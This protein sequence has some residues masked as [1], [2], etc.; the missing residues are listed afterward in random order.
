MTMLDDLSEDEIEQLY[1][2]GL[3]SDEDVEQVALERLSP[4]KLVMLDA[5]AY[6]IAKLF[7]TP[8]GE[9]AAEAAAHRAANNVT[10]AT[11]CG[12][13]PAR[14]DRPMMTPHDYIGADGQSYPEIAA[15]AVQS[16]QQQSPS[17]MYGYLRSGQQQKVYL[18]QA[19]DD[20]QGWFTALAHSQ[21]QPYDY[22]AV[23]AATNLTRPVPG[24]ESFGHTFVS[25]D[26]EIGSWLMPFLLGLPVGAA[27]GYFGPSLYEKASN[28]W[29]TRE[30]AKR[31]VVLRDQNVPRPPSTTSGQWYDIEGPS[32]G[33]PWVDLEEPGYAPAY[34]IGSWVDLVGAQPVDGA[35]RRAHAQSRA[36]IQS[37]INEVKQNAPFAPGAAAFVWSLDPPDAYASTDLSRPFELEGT[38]G[39][40]TF[41]SVADALDYMRQRIQTP[42]VALAL[43]DR[44]SAHWPNP[45]NWTKSTDPTYEPVIA[46]QIVKNAPTRT[47]GWV[48][49]VGQSTSSALEAVRARAKSLASSKPGG[50]AAGVIHSRVDGL[51]H[52]FPFASL[53]DAIDW[54][55]R[56]TYD[57][58]SFTYAAAY[59]KAIDGRAYLQDEEIG[60]VRAVS[61]PGSLG[62]R[63]IATTSGAW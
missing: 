15:R 62:P 44:R 55:Q 13:L 34:T 19:L 50:N 46:Q 35:Q 49:L 2:A 4:H 17:P 58:A 9:L 29:A 38:T 57:R 7:H 5:L 16:T 56:A 18:F 40:R 24:L 52:T 41:N 28:A 27:A 10:S 26:P 23:F 33:G 42:H 21:A 6:G 39:I 61:K 25:G 20:A 36:L 14:G 22:A 59:E 3:V 48:D 45:T 53:D 54:L 8:I 43:F 11:A 32:V 51:W 47:A 60:G 30:A 37:A 12:N 31:G 1:N 63:G